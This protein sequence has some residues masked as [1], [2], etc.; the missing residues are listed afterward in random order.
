MAARAKHLTTTAKR[1]ADE[2]YHDEVGYNYRL[3]NV[4]AAIGVAQLERLPT[5][6][7]R[8]AQ[9]AATYRQALADVPQVRF[10]H[11]DALVTPNEW[12]QTVWI[13]GDQRGLMQHLA[14]RNIQSRPFWVPMNRL[15]MYQQAEYVT[16]RD[17]AGS[18]YA[19]CVSLPSSSNLTDDDVHRVTDAIHGY[20]AR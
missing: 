11:V 18:V 3:V 13:D 12:L 8:K 9:I 4:L 5:M 20:F 15:P 16:Q 19:H 6:L 14:G 10:Q 7:I 17:V 1:S 2:Y